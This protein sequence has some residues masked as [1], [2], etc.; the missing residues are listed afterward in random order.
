M[1]FSGSDRL[2]RS[3]PFLQLSQNSES[4]SR[5]SKVLFKTMCWQKKKSC[6]N[7][8]EMCRSSPF[9]TH[10][11]NC[12]IHA[13]A[14]FLGRDLRACAGKMFWNPTSLSAQLEGGCDMSLELRKNN[15]A[16]LFFGKMTHMFNKLQHV[17]H[18][19]VWLQGARKPHRE[20]GRSVLGAWIDSSVPCEAPALLPLSPFCALT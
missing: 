15:K 8:A 7:N 1:C 18:S 12:D 9:L 19:Q 20:A 16:K 10:G 6:R 13:G 2:H 11:T 17:H 14:P 3:S 4:H 5:D